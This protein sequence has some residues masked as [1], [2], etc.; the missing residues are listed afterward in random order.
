M[1]NMDREYYIKKGF[2]PY[3]IMTAS[4]KYTRGIEIW[5]PSNPIESRN[6]PAVYILVDANGK[7]LKIG[8]TQNLTSRFHQGYRCISNTT[9]DRIRQ[10]I[11]EVE[12]IWVYI[13][14]MPIVK[15]KILGYVCETSY[16]KGLE[17]ELLLAY[18]DHHDAVPTL[19]V[20]IK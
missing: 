15:E 14:P 1:Q 12:S 6:Q 19:N 3:A 10:H 8:E 9:N 11:K 7:L 4:D 17:R 13:L 16:T 20:Y 18:K 5:Y 2:E